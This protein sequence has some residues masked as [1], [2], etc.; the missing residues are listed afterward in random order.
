MNETTTHRYSA[1]C[2]WIGSTAT[3]YELYG[4]EHSLSASPAKAVIHASSNPAFRGDP[5]L[6]NPEQ[7]LVMAA[8][9]CQMLS[10]LA[11]AARKRIDVVEYT[12]QAEGFMPEADKPLRITRIMLRPHIVIAGQGDQDQIHKMVEL[13]HRQCFI[14]NSLKTDIDIAARVEFRS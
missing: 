4:R 9:S 10:F 12:D 11:I 13:A 2:N 5:T 8:A 3:G 6:L 1:T 7:L 14:A